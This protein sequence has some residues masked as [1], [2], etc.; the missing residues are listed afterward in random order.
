MCSRSPSSLCTLHGSLC[1]HP[2]PTTNKW[3]NRSETGDSFIKSA[4]EFRGGSGQKQGWVGR[5]APVSL[6]NLCPF[7]VTHNMPDAQS[8]LLNRH[9]P[10]S[11]CS[12][13]AQ[14]RCGVLCVCLFTPVM[15]C[16]SRT[17]TR[18]VLQ[19]STCHQPS[20]DPHAI[21]LPSQQLSTDTHYSQQ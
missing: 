6:A 8:P 20:S 15:R 11:P 14:Y 5:V 3:A 17:N 4:G 1:P 21:S 16:V 9:L 18:Q 13:P 2:T 19:L 7:C 12:H 10:K